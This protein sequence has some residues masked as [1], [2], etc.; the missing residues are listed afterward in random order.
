MLWP[1]IK[2][3][4][5]ELG[6]KRT[7]SEVVGIIRNCFVKMYDGNQI[8]VLELYV[9]EIDDDDKNF[10]LKNLESNKVKRYEW[11]PNGVKIIF[12]EIIMPYSIK[13][14]KSLLDEF[15]KYF[16]NKYPAQR[17]QCQHC[18]QQNETEVYCINNVSLI[19]CN[20][21]YKQIEKNIQNETIEQQKIQGNYLLGLLGAVLFSIPGIL[22]TILFFVF[23]NSLAAVSAVIYIILG[24]K[25]YKKFKGKISPVGAVIVVIAGLIMVAVGVTVSYSVLILKE[26]KRIDIGA[27]IYILKMPEVQK[28]LIKN[29]VISYIVSSFYFAFQLNQM[30]KE[31]KEKKSIHKPREI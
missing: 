2:K 19:I 31:W 12:T 16:S 18:G 3:L 10:I 1:G 21:C 5:K 8:K 27:L 17:L 6:L 7:D 14:I 29:I 15:V 11:L 9:P 20:D 28:V 26:I 4:G 30:L 23:F 25:G 13:K 22:L 24:I